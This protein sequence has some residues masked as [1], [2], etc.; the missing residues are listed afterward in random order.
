LGAIVLQGL[1][2]FAVGL[3]LAR[4]L[5]PADFGLMALAM[6]V[7]GF[8]A[9]FGDLGLA[10]AIVQLPSLSERHIR[11]AFTG[12]LFFGVVAAASLFGLS[13]ILASVAG[14]GAVAPILRWL[15]LVFV[16]SALGTTGS[17]LLRRKLD[18]KTIF[19]I[20]FAG[21][22]T[23][24]VV[25][26]SLAFAGA[27]VWSLVWG[28]LIQRTIASGSALALT[29]HNIR[30]LWSRNE[31]R[32]LM[33][34]GTGMSL[35]GFA[36]YVALYGDNF[37][38]GRLLGPATLGL[39][40]RAYALMMLPTSYAAA[41]TSAVLFPAFAE[42]RKDGGVERL[43]RA[44][45]IAV[46]F[47]ALLAAPVLA[48][49]IFVA[50]HIIRGLYGPKWEQS[51]VPFQLLCVAGYFRAIYHLGGIVT[52]ATGEVYAE[53]RRQV[54]YAAAVIVGV[55]VGSSMGIVGAASGV[56]FA[57]AFMYGAM[58]ALSKRLT[59][60][61]WAQFCRAQCPGV[62]VAMPVSVAS[63]GTRLVMEHAG[64]SSLA[65]V[66]TAVLACAIAFMAGV[67]LIPQS[68]RPVQL[69]TAIGRM[70]EKAPV[71]LRTAVGHILHLPQSA[72]ST[73]LQ[74]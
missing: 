24:A 9:M 36:N 34:F 5:P 20:D 30:P 56:A 10:P 22:T 74:P 64:F 65:I 51:I 55:A 2:Q 21:V 48:G 25:S 3:V 47:T 6:V 32:E 63:L 40:A 69:F 68:Y 7:V 11:V 39:Y 33:R 45:L 1:L 49:M 59:E 38:V 31:F 26:L 35:S 17:A 46:E 42:A 50:P 71:T 8:A 70:A 12:S 41:V 57:I 44:Y 62:L 13:P 73:A 37:L 27:G 60:S 29:R 72:P 14:N 23:S 54:L 16:L 66:L 53:F 19:V 15:A 52:Q 4:K 43:R 28:A 18:F 61:T 67:Y 58:S